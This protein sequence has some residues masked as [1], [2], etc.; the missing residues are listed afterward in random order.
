MAEKALPSLET[1]VGQV[2]ER[3][4]RELDF[5]ACLSTETVRHFHEDVHTRYFQPGRK[6]TLL[7][8]ALK[9]ALRAYLEKQY[10]YVEEWEENPLRPGKNIITGAHYQRK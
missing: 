8:G 7:K 9:R 2:V 10:C 6:E 5:P 3:R 1:I 4:L